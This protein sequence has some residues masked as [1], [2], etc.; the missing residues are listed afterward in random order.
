MFNGCH[1]ISQILA[2]SSDIGTI[3]SNLL[4]KRLALFLEFRKP[5]IQLLEFL[6]FLEVAP[7]RAVLSDCAF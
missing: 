4:L 6:R 3:G 5:F 1:K 7:A 2:L